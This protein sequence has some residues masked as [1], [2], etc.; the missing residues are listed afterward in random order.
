M[1]IRLDQVDE[2][3]VW[4]ETLK[5]SCQELDIPELVDFDSVECRGKVSLMAESYLLRAALSYDYALRCM[6]CLKPVSVSSSNDL[7]LILEVGDRAPKKGDQ[8]KAPEPELE[9][10]QDDLG[11]LRLDNAILDTRPLIIEQVHLSIPMK[12]LCKEDCAGLC[13]ECGADLNS[14]PCACTTVTDPRWQALAG[15]KRSE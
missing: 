2:P 1:K 8:Q 5:V 12:P 7:E 14:G 15:L 4:Q 9:L 6:R 10:E 11:L 3:F 13:A